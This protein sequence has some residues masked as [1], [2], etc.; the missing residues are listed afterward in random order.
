MRPIPSARQPF[1]FLPCF[2]PVPPPL[3]QGIKTGQLW[4]FLTQVHLI[5]VHSPQSTAALSPDTPTK[6]LG[7][8]RSLGTHHLSLFPNIH[9]Y[10]IVVPSGNTRVITT[11]WKTLSWTFLILY[12]FYV[13]C[14]EAGTNLV[15]QLS[16]W[17]PVCPF[18]PPSQHPAIPYPFSQVP[19]C[20]L[21]T[22]T[23]LSAAFGEIIHYSNMNSCHLIICFYLSFW[24]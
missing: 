8:P 19:S 12:V 9:G 1:D 21:S 16:C 14:S 20:H 4:S 5:I 11:C 22:N 13:V 6:H 2:L 7:I 17:D 18:C 10:T 23:V 3:P 24:W 15:P